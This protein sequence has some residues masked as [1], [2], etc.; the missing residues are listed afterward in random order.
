[1]RGFPRPEDQVDEHHGMEN[2]ALFAK[3]GAVRV[4]ALPVGGGRACLAKGCSKSTILE[5]GVASQ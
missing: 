1:M 5:F 4:G 2:H 3:A